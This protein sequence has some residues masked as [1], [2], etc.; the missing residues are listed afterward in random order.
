MAEL[1]GWIKYIAVFFYSTIKSA[2]RNMM[3]ALG[4]PEDVL[5]AVIGWFLSKR[6]GALAEFGEGLLLGALASLGASGGIVISGLFGGG[7]R[8]TA[9]AQPQYVPA[10]A[11]EY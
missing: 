10:E 7:A 11:V 5:F 6:S 3:P 1:S 9:T 2:V 4:I 8:A